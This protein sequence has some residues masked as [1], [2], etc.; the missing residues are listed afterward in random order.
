MNRLRIPLDYRKP[1][2]EAVQRGWTL[3]S[4][5]H[6]HPKLTAPD[7]YSIPVPTT[8]SNPNTF[9]KFMKR[10]NSHVVSLDQ[11]QV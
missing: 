11:E 2:A 1:V 8:T 3:T 7:G 5:R 10:L 4:E 6:G 9:K